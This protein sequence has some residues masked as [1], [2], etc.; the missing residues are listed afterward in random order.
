MTVAIDSARAAKPV[1]TLF[2]WLV[3]RRLSLPLSLMLARTRVRPS[4]VTAVG[5]ASGLAG[6]ALLAT[7][8]FRLGVAGGIAVAIAKLLDAVDG[9]VAR[10][11]H[12]DTPGGYVA[13]GLCDRLRD[14]SVL[15]GLGVGASRAGVSAA[16][17]WTVAAIAGYLAFFYVS[18]AAPAHWREVR[19]DRDLDDKHMFRVTPRVRLGAGDTLAIVVLAAA[20]AGRPV[21]P[22]Y[23]VAAC[24]PVAIA[25]KVRRVFAARLWERPWTEVPQ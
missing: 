18:G 17:W 12:L 19:D 16:S 4:H 11:K 9:E 23:A 6:A 24:A 8:S 21:W 13:D 3:F 22:V 10:A 25:M 7:G 15:V 2:G 14:T 1:K 20:V 5:L